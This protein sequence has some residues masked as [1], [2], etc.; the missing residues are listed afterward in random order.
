MK[1]MGASE[2]PWCELMNPTMLDSPA[3]VFF[4]LACGNSQPLLPR[5]QGQAIPTKT[6]Y[7]SMIACQFLW[8]ASCGT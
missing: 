8:R 1:S 6:P 3:L 5:G 2:H 4:S 7:R